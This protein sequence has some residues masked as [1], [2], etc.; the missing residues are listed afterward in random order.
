MSLVGGERCVCQI[1][2][3]MK[4]APST[5]S[6]HISVLKHAGLLTSRKD[7]RWVFYTLPEGIESNEDTYLAYA[8][9]Q[10]LKKDKEII[11]DAKKLNQIL[12]IYNETLCKK[13]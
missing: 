11:K 13:C 8:T 5:V 6:K 12:C 7:G 3:L 2:E 4:L 10:R 9:M 1:T